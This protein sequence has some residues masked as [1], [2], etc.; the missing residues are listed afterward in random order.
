LTHFFFYYFAQETSKGH[1]FYSNDNHLKVI[2][3]ISY[4]LEEKTEGCFT[5]RLN[6][7][8]LFEPSLYA[9]NIDPQQDVFLFICIKSQDPQSWS[10]LEP[11]FKLD[12]TKFDH[13]KLSMI[14]DLMNCTKNSRVLCSLF[15][16]IAAGKFVNRDRDYN[17]NLLLVNGRN[18]F[19]LSSWKL[20]FTLYWS[21]DLK[22]P[23]KRLD[24]IFAKAKE[25]Y[26]QSA[27]L[28]KFSAGG[29][30]LSQKVSGF[31]CPW[32]IDLPF[33]DIECLML[34]LQSYHQHLKFIIKVSEY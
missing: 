14:P 5:T 19:R 3:Y 33:K 7:W 27:L 21:N 15:D 9:D 1:K 16:I 29:I 10:Q 17:V 34:H 30:V 32:C 25:V 24:P 26:D 8:N 12:K 6:L 31:R 20:K 22:S 28:Y 18:D 23:L 4:T 13:K 2:N 11:S